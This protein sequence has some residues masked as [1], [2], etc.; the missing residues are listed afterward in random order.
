[1][2]GADTSAGGLWRPGLAGERESGGKREY[3]NGGPG[4]RRK[5]GKT[6]TRGMGRGKRTPF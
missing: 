2:A 4:W 1:M 5:G 3:E 6:Q